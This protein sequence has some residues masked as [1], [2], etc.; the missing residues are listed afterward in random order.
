MN[1]RDIPRKYRK[2]YQ[3]AINNNSRK[4]AIRMFCIECVGYEGKEVPLC[5]DKGCPLFKYRLKG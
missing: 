4:T 1:E 5:T 2:L 3:K